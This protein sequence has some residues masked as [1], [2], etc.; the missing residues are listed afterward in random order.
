M[1]GVAEHEARA[2]ANL[3]FADRFASDGEFGWAVVALFYSAVHHG[4][5]LLSRDGVDSTVLDHATREYRLDRGH[6]AIMRW[7]LS[8]K[9]MSVRCRYVPTHTEDADS[10]R[11][12]RRSLEQIADY[13]R[14]VHA[15][16]VPGK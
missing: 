12:A 15:D 14:R 11:R 6:P 3:A 10:F 1:A 9:G 2:A 7:Y 4:S 16:E 5:A 13:C 8:L